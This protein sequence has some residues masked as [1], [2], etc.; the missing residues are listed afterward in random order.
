[1]VSYYV[2][3][4]NCVCKMRRFGDTLGCTPKII[5]VTWPRPCPFS[6]FFFAYFLLLARYVPNVAKRS[7]WEQ[8]IFWGPTTD[9]RPTDRHHIL[10]NFERPYLWNV[11]VVRSTSCVILGRI[12]GDGGSNGPTSGWTKSKIRPPAILENFEWPYLWN[13]LS[14]PLSW[15]TEQLWRNTG[16]NNAG[17]VIRLVTI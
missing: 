15:I 6:R 7:T 13:K 4:S 3:C 8:C 16:E 1:M 9:Q 10:E 12:F 17:G 11:R 2:L 5:G 14:D